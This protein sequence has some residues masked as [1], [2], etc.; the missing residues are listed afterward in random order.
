M[1][2]TCD[3]HM[4]GDVDRSDEV[5]LTDLPRPAKAGDRRFLRRA[6]VGGHAPAPLAP[7]PLPLACA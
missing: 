1:K 2:A 5:T 7:R 3:D 4:L 6:A